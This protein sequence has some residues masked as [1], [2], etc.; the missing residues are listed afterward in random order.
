MFTLSV[1]SDLPNQTFNLCGSQNGGAFGCN[2]NYGTTDANGNWTLT[3]GPFTVSTVGS[4]QEYIVF[5]GIAQSNTVSFTVQAPY[6]NYS[7]SSGF[8]VG[9]TFT[10]TV[11]TDLPNQSFNLCGSLNGGAF[12]CN[13]NFGTTDSNG[14]WSFTGGPF[15]PSDVG[16][17]QEYIVFPG[18]VQSG[19]VS[20]TVSP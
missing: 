20:F 10:L 15:G 18:I 2:V 6:A 14:N 19:T 16:S 11:N 9:N 17:W 8:H 4:W 3:G 5:P 1:S 12:G 7:I 13:V